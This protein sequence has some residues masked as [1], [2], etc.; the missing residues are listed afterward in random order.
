MTNHRRPRRRND[1][2]VPI[3]AS[4]TALLLLTGISWFGL[5]DLG[6]LVVTSQDTPVG[7]ASPT[8]SADNAP[9]SSL[10][11]TTPAQAKRMPTKSLTPT[12]STTAPSRTGVRTPKPTVKSAP[13]P[14]RTSSPTPT[15]TA[16][17]NGSGTPEAQVL[18]LTNAERAKVGCGPLR[19]N[20]ALTEAAEEHAA[21]MVDH[22]YFSHDSLDGRNP[23][24]RMRDAGY[25]GGAMAENIAVGYATAAAVVDGW[26][27]S[28]GHRKNMLNCTYKVIGIGYD[29]GQVK[30]E[31]GN[32]SW[33]QDFG[34]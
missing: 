3:L 26:M 23:F 21:D 29:S 19:M 2:A 16:T 10:R 12:R 30:P 28:D 11:P 13:T 9:A 1:L 27:N 17:T 7:T 32:G 31:W 24:D 33:V 5:R 18:E 8:P 15:R 22:H 4:V 25:S 20:S 34:S 6:A 14:T